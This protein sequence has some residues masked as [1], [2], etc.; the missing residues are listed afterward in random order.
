MVN[1]KWYSIKELQLN[2]NKLIKLLL[3]IPNENG[4]CSKNITHGCIGHPTQKQKPL[5][6]KNNENNKSN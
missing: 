1:G 6:F 4:E 2:N 3:T 5:S